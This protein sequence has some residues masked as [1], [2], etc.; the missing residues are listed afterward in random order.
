MSRYV[1]IGAA[2]F[3]LK[4][5]DYNWGMERLIGEMR[6]YLEENLSPVLDDKPDLIVLP[7]VCDEYGNFTDQQCLEYYEAKEDY[8]LYFF[9]RMAAERRVHIAYPTMRKMPDGTFRN[10]TYLIDAAGKLLG[11][12]HKNY[13]VIHPGCAY[14]T[15]SGRDATVFETECGRCA[16]VTCFDLNFEELCF[17]YKKQKPELLLFSSLFHGGI[18]QNYWAYTLRSYLIGAVAGLECSIISP[19]GEKLFRSTN[20]FHYLTGTI[21]LDY[22]VIHL[23]NHFEKLSQI[24]RKYGDTVRISDPGHLGCVMLTSESERFSINKIAEEFELEALDDYLNRSRIY[25]EAT[26]EPE[27]LKGEN[28]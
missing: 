9:Q 28:L 24:K 21:N 2:G 17:K 11:V 5:G 13:S 25:R 4:K 22:T 16:C 18:L 6:L 27:S 1:K 10:A 19:V 23:D 8:F 3:S 26:L 12:Y 7:E 14:Q 15:L 20:Y